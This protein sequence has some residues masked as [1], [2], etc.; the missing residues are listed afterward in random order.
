VSP[1]ELRDQI[2]RPQFRLPDAGPRRFEDLPASG[3]PANEQ[4][5]SRTVLA[6][7][8]GYLERHHLVRRRAK[9]AA[10]SATTGPG[11]ATPVPRSA[12][13]S[14][15]AQLW[16][17]TPVLLHWRFQST[18]RLESRLP[19]ALTQQTRAPGASSVNSNLGP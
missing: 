17:A 8:L 3:W 6:N 4:A 2:R 13:A 1:S 16:P 19:G 12:A 5:G 14:R 7:V 18:T 10:D 9:Q 15:A 11:D